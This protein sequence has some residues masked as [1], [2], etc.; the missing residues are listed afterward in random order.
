MSV[1][2]IQTYL[3]RPETRT[4]GWTL[5]L[6]AYR[7]GVTAIIA[8]L[9]TAMVGAS[10]YG[11]YA[12][13]ISLLA[14]LSVI[15]L[16]GFERLSVREVAR[17][18]VKREWGLLRGYL[19][20]TTLMVVVGSLGILLV[21]AAVLRFFG[22]A[23][24][25]DMRMASTL[26]VIIFPIVAMTL[27]IQSVIRGFQRVLLGQLPEEVVRPTTLILLSVGALLLQVQPTAEDVL[28]YFA[29]ATAI[30]CVA[31]F[32]FLPGR[33]PVEL[34]HTT[35]E[36]RRGRWM[37]DSMVLFG[38]GALVTLNARF[39]VLL[40][41][42]LGTAQETGIFALSYTLATLLSFVVVAVNRSLGPRIATYLAQDRLADVQDAVLSM[43]RL[44]FAA[45]LIPGAAFI[46]F[47]PEILGIFGDEFRE[48]ASSL[49]VLT[50]GQLIYV[51]SGNAGLTLVMSGNERIAIRGMAVGSFVT[52]TLCAALIPFYGGA[53]AAVAMAA[54]TIVSNA[55]LVITT[56]RRLGVATTII[57]HRSS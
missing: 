15:G 14:V 56:Y 27:H 48:G 55:L 26:I 53:G 49:A 54:G 29:V 12:F 10:G 46:F 1:F 11:V 8:F 39:G 31:A 36:Y 47:G 50:V 18:Y 43:T 51:A 32:I 57:G 35:A 7:K 4:A 52:V 23:L 3:Q 44:S 13:A 22:D 2:R 30:S 45:A 6:L 42:V 25:E 16:F 20:F 40:L 41:G 19:Q 34:R 21:G 38:F 37:R 24:T 5:A 33:I 28:Y 9:L 17:Y